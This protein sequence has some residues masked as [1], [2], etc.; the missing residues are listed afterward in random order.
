MKKS[1]RAVH[2]RV[3]NC[4]WKYRKRMGFTQRQVAAIL[5]HVS[6]PNLSHLERGDKLPSLITALKLE[7]NYRVPVAFQFPEHYA[8]LKAAIRQKEEVV[9][10]ASSRHEKAA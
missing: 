1:V 4:L 3:A 2:G 5:T 10:T 8:R 6:Q 9:R 7:I